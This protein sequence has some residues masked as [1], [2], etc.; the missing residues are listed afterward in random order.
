ML[1]LPKYKEI[2]LPPIV[3]P[4]VRMMGE[5]KCILRDE[6]GRAVLETPWNRNTILDQ[7]LD[8]IATEQ[9][10]AKATIGSSNL[11]EDETQTQLQSP[12]AQGAND[13]GSISAWNASSPYEFSITRSYQFGIGV[14]TGTVQEMGV[15]RV[16]QATSGGLYCRHVIAPG[17][18]KGA[19][20]ALDVFYKHTIFPPLGDVLTNNVLVDGVNYDRTLRGAAY[21]QVLVNGAMSLMGRH[22]AAGSSFQQHYDGDIDASV[23]GLPAGSS[24]TDYGSFAKSGYVPLNYFVDENVSCGLNEANVAGGI[25]RSSTFPFNGGNL[26]V[27]YDSTDGPAIGTG[28]PKDNTKVLNFTFRES[29]VRHP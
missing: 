2:E 17:I 28:L 24:I 16:N 26:Q 27:M 7:G 23:T 9:C 22:T 6:M 5:F 1:I 15:H 29:W 11:A 12:L 25:L 10:F 3:S 20:Q 8:L 4:S 13:T 21:G 14:G 18:V 19:S